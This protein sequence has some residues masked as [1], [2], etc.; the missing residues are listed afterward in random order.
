MLSIQ[1]NEKLTRVGAGTP[2][3]DIMRR[4]WMPFLNVEDLGGP[5]GV[6]V[7]VRLLGEDLVAFCDTSGRVGL[8][9]K[10]CPHRL[11]DLWY[12][13]NEEDGLRCTYHGWKYDTTGAC[14]DMPSEHKASNFK[15]KVHL[16]SYPVEEHGGIL[17]T[18][19][20]PKELTPEIPQ[21][22][23]MNVPARHRFSSWNVEECN[24]AQAIEGGIDTVHSVYLHSSMDS[25][26][27]REEWQDAGKKAGD[28][29]LRFRTD[30]NP[31]QLQTHDTDYGVVVGAKYDGD[32]GLDYW[33]F[34]LFWMPFWTAPPGSTGHKSIHAFV[35]IDDVTT[36][37]WS[38]TL[39]D[40]P[41]PA[42]DLAAMRKGSGL[43]SEVY[44]GT[45]NPTHHKRNNYQIDREMQRLETYTG[46]K[47]FG[48]QDYSVQEGMGLISNRNHE[49]LAT[50][51]IG[52]IAMR[53][54]LLRAANDLAEGIQPASAHDGAAYL[55]RPGDTQLPS[56]V[57]RWPEHE[58][59]VTALTANWK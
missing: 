31:P 38:F 4:Y 25:H 15:E 30:D 16:T 27:N 43:H 35:P 1:D 6:P 52:I 48:A 47:D 46:I 20:G 19:M 12:G 24:F 49:H 59:T 26:R 58:N 22:E 57:D 14:I 45:H 18:Y 13:R 10:E 11:A 55:V 7:R 34:N 51:D 53:R 36:M 5:D 56:D 28:P 54:R 40:T 3:G 9:S 2:M 50:T 44:P 32:E 29:R 41:I 42:R 17:F 21:F 39:S 33:R 23:W 8:V 37:R